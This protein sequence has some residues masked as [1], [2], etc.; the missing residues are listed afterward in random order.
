MIGFLS[1]T[2]GVATIVRARALTTI[3]AIATLRVTN[4]FIANTC[5]AAASAWNLRIAICD[6]SVSNGQSANDGE[7]GYGRADFT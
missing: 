4:A 6:G 3:V 5:I 7:Y 1:L 2:A